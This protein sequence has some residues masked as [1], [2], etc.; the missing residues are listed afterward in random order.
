[1]E[2]TTQEKISA[3]S[4][5]GYLAVTRKA[6]LPDS[7]AEEAYQENKES[8]DKLTEF[9]L[10]H[11]LEKGKVAQDIFGAVID[12]KMQD[13]GGIAGKRLQSFIDRIERI[14]GEK[15]ELSE[16]IKEIYAEAKGVGFDTKTI[17]K[18]VTLRKI[19]REKREE[20]KMLLELYASAIGM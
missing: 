17:R 11:D 14:E 15:A 13:I 16:D 20:Q 7:L 5:A 3:V 2:T 18:I 6:G 10:K 9:M 12:A 19:D 4:L 1:M 8:T